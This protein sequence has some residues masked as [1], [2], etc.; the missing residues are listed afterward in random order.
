MSDVDAEA[1]ITSSGSEPSTQPTSSCNDTA[2]D[3]CQD[4]LP[5][6]TP[7][8]SGGEEEQ[9]SCR[10]ETPVASQVR[11]WHD[12]FCVCCCH[13]WMADPVN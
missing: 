4:P 3:V 11:L 1:T 7:P 5:P 10:P 9:Q 13:P 12:M 8:S 2:C 6:L